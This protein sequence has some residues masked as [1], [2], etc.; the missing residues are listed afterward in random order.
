MCGGFATWQYESVRNNKWNVLRM[1]VRA[2]GGVVPDTNPGA[3]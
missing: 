3:K 2:K 1:A